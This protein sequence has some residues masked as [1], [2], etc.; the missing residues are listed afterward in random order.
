MKEIKIQHFALALLVLIAIVW[1]IGYLKKKNESSWIP[2]GGNKPCN[3]T[4]DKATNC[5]REYQH[6]TGWGQMVISG[7]VVTQA[8]QDFSDCIKS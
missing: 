2:F 7:A 6:R 3:L 4:C 8:T 1:I 5:L